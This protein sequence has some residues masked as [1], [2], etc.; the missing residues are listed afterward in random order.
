MTTPQRKHLEAITLMAQ[1]KSQDRAALRCWNETD[2]FQGT[3]FTHIGV[4][5]SINRPRASRLRLPTPCIKSSLF[6]GPQP[7]G[8]VAKFRQFTLEIEP[9]M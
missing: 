7:P 9:H 1:P 6:I 3:I 2:G 5:I 8:I 4:P